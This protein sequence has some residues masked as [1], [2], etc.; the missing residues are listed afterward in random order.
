MAQL[1]APRL[2]IYDDDLTADDRLL[3]TPSRLENHA[4]HK[5]VL[6]PN[7][8]IENRT[9]VFESNQPR[10][11]DPAELRMEAANAERRKWTEPPSD[12]SS[13]DGHDDDGESSTGDATT[14][15]HNVPQRPK[16]PEMSVR[17]SID[18]GS[19]QALVAFDGFDSFDARR[20]SLASRAPRLLSLTQ[21]G[22][23]GGAKPVAPYVPRYM[24]A[25]TSADD[26]PA[27]AVTLGATRWYRDKGHDRGWTP[28]TAVMQ[29]RPH[30]A[31]KVH[32]AL[33]LRKAANAPPTS[34]GRPNS[35]MATSRASTPAVGA[36]HRSLQLDTMVGGGPTTAI[37]PTS[38][39]FGNSESPRSRLRTAQAADVGASLMIRRQ[40][41]RPPSAVPV[42]GPIPASRAGTPSVVRGLVTA[43]DRPSTRGPPP[44]GLRTPT[45]AREGRSCARCATK[46]HGEQVR[47]HDNLMQSLEQRAL[48]AA[49]L[50][51]A[52]SS[53][54]AVVGGGFKPPM[55]LARAPTDLL[56]QP[57][58]PLPVSLHML[59]KLRH[60]Q[61]VELAPPR[62]ALS[63]DAMGR[64]AH[65][66]TL[67][68]ELAA[69]ECLAADTAEA[70]D[71]PT[72][73]LA[74]PMGS[75]DSDDEDEPDETARAAARRDPE[76][77][78]MMA[79]LR[80]R[81]RAAERLAAQAQFGALPPTP[82]GSDPVLSPK[83]GG[84][85][86][87]SNPDV[88]AGN[89]AGTGKPG[90]QLGGSM[91]GTAGRP[92]NKLVSGVVSVRELFADTTHRDR[93]N[94][95]ISV[96]GGLTLDL[97]RD[98]FK[99]MALR[100]LGP[101]IGIALT[102]DQV[103]Y[104]FG[105]FDLNNG[106]TVS[107]FEYVECLCNAMLSPKQKNFFQALYTRLRTAAVTAASQAA[108]KR[109]P[110][111]LPRRV[112]SPQPQR[113]LSASSQRSRVG[114]RR[115][116]AD[117]EAHGDRLPYFPRKDSVLSGTLPVGAPREQPEDV[118][119]GLGRA[120]MGAEL[121]QKATFDLLN[122]SL[123]FP[124]PAEAQLAGVIHACFSDLGATDRIDEEKFA[125]LL[126]CDDA[127]MAE[128]PHHVN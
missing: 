95:Y 63:A 62:C 111:A 69:F 12:T 107:Y 101:R 127:V 109:R 88:L 87:T 53:S 90:Q 50:D 54:S 8:L 22:G 86:S 99:I 125:L 31:E 45:A 35:R 25:A 68:A 48:T 104:L 14:P 26:G 78:A 17:L 65:C 103:A 40:L 112:S 33:D 93:E 91:I 119:N 64:C 120:D 23:G 2:L 27:V 94:L 105:Q 113:L 32:E 84:M 28:G 19:A 102:D 75:G 43:S 122:K 92:S 51:M 13:S 38:A 126:F 108:G 46:S 118:A 41:E 11:R 67:R 96:V 59:G 36:M 34:T 85:T 29:A 89:G 1:S 116:S 30:G 123:L 97:T 72:S 47:C 74:R 117:V 57:P 76:F 73:P 7:G 21:G 20:P 24:K 60:A 58:Q 10:K 80:G 61:A 9:F 124:H 49:G 77:H 4:V 6:G 114:R 18:A 110:S 121:V 83:N 115:D 44:A 128:L 66:D 56:S 5:P 42:L 70:V 15:Q 81:W 37:R 52:G 39:L 82:G 16:E 71:G 106:G 100:V 98:R 79:P 3:L 55:R